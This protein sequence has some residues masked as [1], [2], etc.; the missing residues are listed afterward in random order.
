MQHLIA[1][2]AVGL[3]AKCGDNRLLLNGLGMSHGGAT[4]FPDV[5]QAL[6]ELR[7]RDDPTVGGIQ[8]TP[9]C[10]AVTVPSLSNPKVYQK[11]F[12]HWG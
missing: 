12:R 11:D 9:A 1:N 8:S 4:I 7:M 5:N 2:N 10:S 3:A 6:R